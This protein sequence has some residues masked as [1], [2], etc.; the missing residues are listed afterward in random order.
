MGQL[1]EV[2]RLLQ[3]VLG[4]DLIGVYLSGSAVDGGLRPR[5]D[6][7]ILAVTARSLHVREKEA[8]IRGLM[9]LSADGQP[10]PSRRWLEVTV[11]ARPAV[12]PWRFPPPMELQYGEWWRDAFDAGEMSPWADPNRDLA[13]MLAMALRASRTLQGPPLAEVLGPIP[14]ADVVQ[15]TMDTLDGL[16]EDLD[17]DTRNVVLT[18]VRAW[19]TVAEGALLSKAAAARWAMSRLPPQHRPVL[20]RALA[21][22]L[23]GGEDRWEGLGP[24][25]RP[26]ADHVAAE[27]RASRR[28]G[29]P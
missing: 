8:L 29:R 1:D 16:L 17:L 21:V 3:R 2:V 7:D 4:T 24:R 9:P 5:S 14:M 19:A 28:E 20:D 27:I 13:I 25:I 26:F 12:S 18:L 22:Y 11:V 10:I 15:A 23:A 6:L